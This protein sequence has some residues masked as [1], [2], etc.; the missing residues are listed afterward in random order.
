MRSG[1]APGAFDGPP[2]LLE[3]RLAPLLFAGG[4]VRPPGSWSR[5]VS[6]TERERAG[7]KTDTAGIDRP[8]FAP[9]GARSGSN[10]ASRR[11]HTAC[12]ARRWLSANAPNRLGSLEL[13]VRR[14]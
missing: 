3:R 5:L 8:L 14:R 6:P 7:G 9:F 4:M 13:R 1:S 2:R 10:P 12:E 11:P